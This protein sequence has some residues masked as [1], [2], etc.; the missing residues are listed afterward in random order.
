MSGLVFH[1]DNERDQRTQFTASD[2]MICKHSAVMNGYYT[3][4]LVSCFINTDLSQSGGRSLQPKKPPIINRGYYARVH[5]INQI[6]QHF[7]SAA[8]KTTSK[9][10][11]IINLGSGFDTL[12]LQLLQ[13]KDEGLHIFEIDFD[14]IVREKVAT[15][16][17]DNHIR[18]LLIPENGTL[19]KNLTRDGT[20][21]KKA[22]AMVACSAKD[23]MEKENAKFSFG[24]IHFISGDLREAKK[25]VD[26]LL[27]AGIEATAPTLIITECVLVYLEKDES[28]RLSVELSSLLS[29]AAWVTY[30]MI[31][32]NDVFGKTMIKNLTAARFKIPGFVDYPSLE[33]QIG[34][35]LGT[36]WCEA[37]CI[38][39]LTVYDNY[40][41]PEERKRISRLEIFDEI[42]EWQM[43]M[44]H[45]SLTVAIKGAALL[46]VLPEP[47]SPT[48]SKVIVPLHLTSTVPRKH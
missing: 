37:R 22:V 8:D 41:S 6:I 2:A 44:S 24:N 5:G 28:E 40:I 14:K 11:Q 26:K 3:D 47:I 45:Y 4:D 10:R 17:N 23:T 20:N 30:D 27:K 15:C 25:I 1:V 48:V 34:R 32:P 18:H 29:E 9:R 35:F 38:S 33:A 12:S 42:E 46:T 13:R 31:S 21:H 16:L 36:G 39:M 7:L 43:L 19:D